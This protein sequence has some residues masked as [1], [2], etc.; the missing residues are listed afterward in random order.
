V[1]STTWTISWSESAL[2]L[3]GVFKRSGL[4]VKTQTLEELTACLEFVGF[5][6]DSVAMVIRLP[7]RKLGELRKLL[8]E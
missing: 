7:Q 6:A 8:Q 4:P 1:S 2:A 3:S 5:E